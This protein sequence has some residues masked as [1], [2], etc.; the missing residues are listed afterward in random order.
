MSHF[1]SRSLRCEVSTAL[2]KIANE[3]GRHPSAD[4]PTRGDSEAAFSEGKTR[5]SQCKSYC[6]I[7]R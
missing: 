7:T 3:G 4:T 6:D 2:R 5:L 1:A